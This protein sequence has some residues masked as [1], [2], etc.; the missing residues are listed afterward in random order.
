MEVRYPLLGQAIARARVTAG[1]ANQR[2]L[3]L[4]LDV[5]QQSIS[6][7]E[8][9]THR[10][11]PEQVADLAA[12]LKLNAGE[13]SRMAGYAPLPT[14]T[15]VQPFPI[16]HLDPVTFEYFIADV[17]QRRH[18]DAEVRRA[19]SSGHKQD[20]VD[21]IAL[22]ADGRRMGFQC[23]RAAKFG[24]AEVKRVV[25]A[26]TADADQ[27]VLVLSRVAS[28]QAAE[29]LRKTPGWTLW[30]RDDVSRIVRDLPV[31]DQEQLVDLYFPG[32]RRALL[33]SS[34]RGPWLLASEFF[35]PYD[36]R[37]KPFSHSWSLWGREAE[38][39]RL[40]DA[41]DAAGQVTVLV[42][43][44]GMGKSRLLKS[45]AEHVSVKE[46]ATLLRFLSNTAPLSPQSLDDLGP[47]PKILIVD[48]AHDRDG[49]GALFELAS[50]PARQ[51][52]LVMATRPYAKDRILGEAAVHGVVSPRQIALG[53]LSRPRLIELAQEILE[54]FGS[55]TEW[56]EP[57]ARAS[58]DS[59]L[60]VAMVSRVI[61]LERL[62]LESARANND[63]RQ[64]IQGK[65]AQVLEGDLAARGEEHTHRAVLEVLAV[66]QP[67]NLDDARVR[68]LIV[69]V[70]GLDEDQVSRTLKVLIDG[71]VAFRRGPSCRLMPD[72]LGDFLIERA[73]LDGQGALSPLANRLLEAMPTGLLK[74]ALVNLGRLDWRRTEGDTANSGLL[75]AVWRSFDNVTEDWDPRLDAIKAAALYQ[76]R[77][78]LDFISRV[79]QFG[80]RLA[81]FDEVARNIAH[82]GSHFEDVL[83][84]LWDLARES[85][86]IKHGRAN[87]A[88]VLT[89]LGEINRRN[90]HSFVEG[91]AEFGLRLS[92]DE[93]NW[94]TELTP[95]GILKPIMSVEGVHTESVGHNFSLS[96][97]YVNY[98]VVQ[99]W[100]QRVTARV[101]AL[102]SHPNPRV[103]ADAANFFEVALRAPF[104][105]MNSD[106][107]DALRD[108]LNAEFA[109]TLRK[110]ARALKAGVHP[111]AALGIAKSVNWHA[112]HGAGPVKAAA[113]AAM[114]ALPTD[115]HFRALTALADGWGQIFVPIVDANRWQA[116]LEAWLKGIVDAIEDAAPQPEQR[117]A[118]VEAALDELASAG[119]ETNSAQMLVGAL[120]RSDLE[121][122]RA[123]LANA[124]VDPNSSTRDYASMALSELLQKAA[125]EGRLTA[126][127][128]LESG[129]ETLIGAVASGFGGL[130]GQPTRED[131]DILGAV[132]TSPLPNVASRAIT[133]L[134]QWRG[135]DIRTKLD[136]LLKADLAGGT[137]VADDL[138]MALRAGD[139]DLWNIFGQADA[140]RVLAALEPIPQLS[141]H[142]I[143]ELLAELSY[144][145]P[146]ETADFFMR[147]VEMAATANSYE[148]R[149]ANHGSY[150]HKRLQFLETDAGVASL[151]RVWN[152]LAENRDRGS[153][154]DEAASSV[155][156][157]MFAFDDQALVN[158]FGPLLPTATSA[159]LRQIAGLLRRARSEFVLGQTHFI[160]ALLRRCQLV[161][162][163]VLEHA[164][165]QLYAC[166]TSGMRSG[167]AGKPLPRDL[168][169]VAQAELVLSKLSRL[170]PAYRLFTAIRDSAQ[171]SI[172]ETLRAEEMF[173]E[174]E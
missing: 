105:A 100:R 94:S 87:P 142:W 84:L 53:R 106:P 97:Y 115:A 60:F 120:A 126:R 139:P 5:S 137:R 125:D 32:Q 129:D 91:V 39:D 154:F 135:I 45:I 86:Q 58:G 144:R 160:L 98:E 10:P 74:N 18:R 46:P 101:M 83:A 70:K 102:L 131:I 165:I 90:P 111:V 116:D 149:A 158:F 103:A 148:I 150:S 30:D 62:P 80:R 172:D 88:K 156:E 81:A 99:P 79:S 147:R 152:W 48:D 24:P 52:R 31:H 93:D 21:V 170:D 7:W 157:A 123:L 51:V 13:M 112:R 117:R 128:L 132:L 96:A 133:G 61:A 167:Q 159:S 19:G 145:F 29:E 130:G 2:D 95:L 72:V 89:D 42:A 33:G 37:E 1:L 49:L 82:S 153:V 66:V 47:G 146:D 3:A 43:P 59:P 56:A 140:E 138:A 17:V 26:F 67:F 110:L 127:Q 164:F 104:G 9:G 14:V 124:L 169:D 174:E 22:L 68:D 20:G 166:A 77:Q 6:R 143:D 23:K 107:P 122:A 65:F 57:I 118:Y 12:T 4:R 55:P 16:E 38:H 8:A 173:E 27:K 141:G 54:Q 114:K 64:Y 78:A 25:A 76:P 162:P 168:E 85:G 71:G 73:C 34:E 44:G 119:Q 92:E 11:R 40:L 171:R 35:R 28:P 155:F 151:S 113:R 63:L 134:W 136:L 163:D 75:D 109:Q 36:G 69:A 121:F 41:L 50:N 161:D 108:S 15:S